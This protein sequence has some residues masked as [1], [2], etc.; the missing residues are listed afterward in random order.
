MS[1]TDS[2][3]QQRIGAGEGGTVPWR[4][5]RY[6]L[7]AF[8]LLS[9][10]AMCLVLRLVLLIQF[11]GETGIAAA[12]AA[13][14]LL[15]GLH[16]DFV[17]ALMTTLPLLFWL[18]VLPNRWF[19]WKW[20]RALFLAGLCL[21]WSVQVFLFCAEYYF[22]E[23]FRSRF[24]TVAVDYL[25][26]P[27]E[28]F[29]NIWDS[30]PVPAVIALCIA[31]G[32][33]WVWLAMRLF[34]DTWFQPVGKGR[35]FVHFAGGTALAVVL[36]QT[37]SL[38]GTQFSTDRT[39]NEI[40]NNGSLSF[41][42]AAWT[43]NLDYAAFYR[44]LPR[45]EAYARVRRLLASPR[46]EFV[47][48]AFSIRRK[49]AGDPTRPRL[50]VVLILEE[51]LGSEFFGC[52]GREETLTPEMDRLA[53]EEGILFTN[54]YACGNRTVRG[55]EG[56]FS[57]FP[58]LPGDSIVK[59][60][61]SENVESLAR[62]LK[63]DGYQTLFL[64]GGRGIFDGMRSYAL[65]N[66]WDRFIEQKDFKDPT[67]ATIW[68]VCNEDLFTRGIEECRKLAESGEP[69]FATMLTVSNHKPYTYPRGRIP[70][71]PEKP[72]PTRAKA[73]KYTDWCLGQF[74][75]EVKKESFWTNTIF[76]VVA[77]HG[78]RVY[79]SQE[80]PIYSYEI[81]FVILGPAVVKEP[82]RI[83][84]LGNS[85]DV[86]PTILGLLGRPYESMFFGRD[87]F[88]DPVDEGRVL[89]NHNRS[90]GMY[91]DA[92][93]VVLGLKQSVWYYEG[94]PKVTELQRAKEAGPEFIELE[95]DATALYQVAD[96]LYMN[97]LYRIEGV[98]TPGFTAITAR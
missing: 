54:I 59:R 29:I 61:R 26:Y 92:R 19:G 1:N 37:V 11:G 94:D 80:I 30:Y 81:P 36:G 47:G 62:V 56:V 78:A 16:Q 60:D 95:K 10:V 15:I 90:I 31:M 32:I 38:N 96:E 58:P 53:T 82:Q 46:A 14:A 2:Q 40:A 88:N 64:Y 71:D 57:S 70:D 50:N 73:V 86:A 18:W 65:N 79:G 67:F 21:F 22:F 48:D 85:L 27:H 55:F 5:S 72:K 91:A 51:S 28:V 25:L 23:E 34:R 49:V 3:S 45:E 43:R 35:R 69:F 9:L 7:A 97:R 66:G 24:N 42:A 77:D 33:A 39:L 68:G 87:L 6:G 84:T 20:F 76:V 12:G 17:V 13:Q 4:K 75:R 52:L 74:F 98:P 41:V 89:L 44:T 83:G 93:M 63:R 8:F